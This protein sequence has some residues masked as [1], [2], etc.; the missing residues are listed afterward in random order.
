MKKEALHPKTISKARQSRR[1][2]LESMGPSKER[3]RLAKK[4]FDQ[5]HN[6]RKH[7]SSKPPSP[8]QYWKRKA[9]DPETNLIRKF[10]PKGVPK[11]RKFLK[12]VSSLI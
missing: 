12:Y 3:D 2:L 10:K 6:M 8:Q 9:V 7:V 11:H 5:L 4:T 1:K